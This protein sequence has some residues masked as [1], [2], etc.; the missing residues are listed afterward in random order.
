MTPKWEIN[1]YFNKP[2]EEMQAEQYQILPKRTQHTDKS[3]TKLETIKFYTNLYEIGIDEKTSKI[4]Q[5][6]FSLPNEI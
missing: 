3:F 6:D 1:I 5:F 2:K 4:Y